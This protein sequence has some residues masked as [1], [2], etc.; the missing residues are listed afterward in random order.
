MRVFK[1]TYRDRQRKTQTAAKWY[2][3]IRDQ[4]D[5]IRR[6]P[7]FTSK[8]ASEE[9]GRNIERLVA[10][11]HATGGQADPALQSWINELPKNAR[12]KLAAIGLIES[13][14]AAAG[15]ALDIHVTNFTTALNAKGNTSRHVDLVTGRIRSVIDGCGFNY[16]S[17]IT[18][19]KVQNHL[20]GLREGKSGISPQTFNF[21]LQAM[22][23]FCRWMVRERRAVESPLTHLG[24]LNVQLDRRHD[25]RALSVDELLLLLET[26]QDGPVRFGITGAE[27]AIVYRLAVETGLRAGEIRT[28]T[29]S[30]LDLNDKKPTVTVRA[31]YSKNRRQSVLPLRPRTAGI[32]SQRLA[33]KGAAELAFRMPSRQHVAKM[34]RADLEAARTKWLEKVEGDSNE[35]ARREKSDFLTYINHDKQVADFHALRHTFITN[36]ASGGVHPKTAQALA[37]HST[38]ALTMDRYSHSHRENEAA[39]LDALPDLPVLESKNGHTL[40]NGNSGN[41]VLAFCLAQNG[42][43]GEISGDSGRLCSRQDVG[44][45]G[46][47]KHAKSLEISGELTNSVGACTLCGSPGEVAERLNA[48]VS[49][50]GLPKGSGSSN[51][52]L[53]VV[54]EVRIAFW[55]K[56]RPSLQTAGSA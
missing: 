3:E 15:V 7:A 52:P 50:T 12:R 42:T 9:F 31:A 24:G 2:V 18:A 37:R 14:R 28:L 55:A 38:F 53:S 44:A 20:A 39:A 21:Y 4:H 25:R 41:S 40:N 54:T 51:L 47:S 10:Y 36:L 32:L 46:K 1:T 13:R 45:E 17:D 23:Q 33:G 6:I 35:H 26:T 49:K 30:A 16:W 22:K 43:L 8:A 34:V 5:I 48:P 19:A 56:V 29:C 27:R 11:H